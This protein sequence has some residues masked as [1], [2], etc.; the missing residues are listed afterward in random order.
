MKQNDKPDQ[1]FDTIATKFE[2]NIYGSTKG[3]LRHDL[4]LHYLTEH[5]E[6]Q[7]SPL[8]ILDAGGGTG[9]MCESLLHYGHDLTLNDVSKDSLDIAKE[10][11]GSS[12]SVT[13][14]H[15]EIQR[16][17]DNEGFDLVICHAVLEWL[18]HPL[19]AIEHLIQLTAPGGYL[20]ISFFNRDAKLF[21]NLLY[22]NFDY[23]KQGMKNKNTVRLNPDMSLS[24]KDI[25]NFLDAKAVQLIHQAG[26]RCVHDYMFDRSMQT[27]R[28]DEIKQMEIAYGQ[29]HPYCWLGKY[30][31]II[32]KKN[33]P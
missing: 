16:L 3:Q 28:Y 21:G 9:V 10:K 12:Q 20:S 18:K 19:E 14:S 26:I 8:K 31:H 17:V 13:F 33:K 6:L 5:I 30:F 29:Q 15:G 32:L 23:V 7:Q 11:M 1:S 4:L 2:N 27:S 22:G 25:L 24:P